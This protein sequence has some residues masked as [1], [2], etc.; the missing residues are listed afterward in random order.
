MD[1]QTGIK[2]LAASCILR[3]E[4]SFM[5]LKRYKEPYRGMFLPVGGKVDPFESPRN[6]AIRETRE[7]TGLEVDQ[8]KFCGTLVETSP[9]EYN[10]MSF[11]YL[12]DIAHISP[13]ASDEG[14]LEWIGFD[15]LLEKPTPKTDW[16]IY[17]Y[18]MQGWPFAFNADFDQTLTLVEMQEEFENITVYRGH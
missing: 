6:A 7:E 10:W 18:I 15:Q 14:V 13:P 11:I 12:C 2:K 16:Y 3:H 4:Q 1:T 5:L 8:I 17:Q 9:R